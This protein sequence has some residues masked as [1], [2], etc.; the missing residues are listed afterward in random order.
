MWAYSVLQ[1]CL[2]HR[3][4]GISAMKE[5]LGPQTS[6]EI[7]LGS[8]VYFRISNLTMMNVCYSLPSCCLDEGSCK[9]IILKF[10]HC[11]MCVVLGFVS[12]RSIVQTLL[13][14]AVVSGL[15]IMKDVCVQSNFTLHLYL[16]W[17]HS[18]ERVFWHLYVIQVVWLSF[19]LSIL[20]CKQ[21]RDVGHSY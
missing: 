18:N 4:D 16:S 13:M 7:F 12:E 19:S 1:K 6:D 17:E 10:N 8:P 14:S 20:F 11:G 9:N 2:C 5:F 21:F 15:W 3:I